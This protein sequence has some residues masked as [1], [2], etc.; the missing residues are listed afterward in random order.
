MSKF[1]LVKQ[2]Y[3]F[4]T[5]S[6][7]DYSTVKRALIDNL[8]LEFPEVF[9]DYTEFDELI[10]II[11]SFAYI[12]ELFAYRL[13]I[14]AQENFIQTAN[15]KQNVIKLADWIGYT[16][17]RGIP[18]RGLF[19][20]ESVV[21]QYDII[22]VRGENLKNREI[23]WND[24]NN[25]FWKSQFLTVLQQS[26]D[27]E[28]LNANENKR[29]Q[30]GNTIVEQ[31]S[32]ASVDTLFGTANI[33]SSEGVQFNI[34]SSSVTSSGFVENTPKSTNKISLF[35][36]DDNTGD[37]SLNTGFFFDVTQGQIS[38]TNIIIDKIIP[39]NSIKVSAANINEFDVWLFDNT[40]NTF[41][42]TV[43]KLFFNN[44][45]SKNIFKIKPVDDNSIELLFGD[46]ILSNIPVGNFTVFYRTSLNQNLLI[47]KQTIT[48]INVS[49][50]LFFNNVRNIISFKISCGTDLSSTASEDMQHIK[51]TASSH[52]EIQDRLVTEYDYNKYLLQDQRV[53]CANTLPVKSI[54]DSSFFTW[55]KQVNS[56]F[57]L[58]FDDMFCFMDQCTNVK[59]YTNQSAQYV[60]DII[61]GVITQ[62]NVIATSTLYNAVN[63]TRTFFRTQT[64][65]EYEQLK[66]KMGIATSLVAVVPTF[67][68]AIKRSTTSDNWIF[69]NRTRDLNNIPIWKY[70]DIIIVDRVPQNTNTIYTVF[71]KET[72]IAIGKNN[73]NIVTDNDL[74]K[75]SFLFNKFN[76]TNNGVP[77]PSSI[78]FKAIMTSNDVDG[79]KVSNC[80]RVQS[81]DIDN[82]NLPDIKT[83]K[84][85][86]NYCLT[87]YQINTYQ[88]GGSYY[89]DVP[90]T[91]EA[92]MP[93][94]Q[95][96]E[97]VRDNSNTI[98]AFSYDVGD[99]IPTRKIKV[100]TTSPYILATIKQ[101]IYVEFVGGLCNVL[102]STRDVFNEVVGYKNNHPTIK[103][104]LGKSDMLIKYT[105]S[106]PF[107]SV[108]DPEQTNLIR[109]NIITK[110]TLDSY[111]AYVL[112][113]KSV[114]YPTSFDLSSSFGYLLTKRMI[115]DNVSLSSGKIVSF[116]GSSSVSQRKAKISI[117]KNPFGFFLSTDI[118]QTV[119][120]TITSLFDTDYVMGEKI[121]TSQLIG[122]ISYKLINEIQDIK[123]I[124]LD[125][126]NYGQEI[127][128]FM[129]GVDE[130]LFPHI[131]HDD[132]V[133]M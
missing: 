6:A 124:S 80:V 120:D 71:V 64:S 12:S 52:Y 131:T 76:L 62:T 128:Y 121:H 16:P 25:V 123:F 110:G 115:S 48:N 95:D 59:T 112:T 26:L 132:I 7:Y 69:E 93:F 35:S 109:I 56:N 122:I 98:V 103:R 102:K 47:P 20:I 61:D 74:T 119:I 41:W 29:V 77:L 97:L 46:G 90:N 107:L 54:G 13:D 3:E 31:Y 44:S 5:F 133:V 78:K 91:N 60:V 49:I 11:N 75:Q 96:I 39:N 108:V 34:L 129:G 21:P 113:G 89:F 53:L 58:L 42:S 30:I 27:E 92:V 14:N 99:F 37:A 32:L 81:Q 85:D 104:V 45:P 43:D 17:K 15:I 1:N 106:V 55:N 72:Y 118:K 87:T 65:D 100:N 28:V 22:D 40:N 57:D 67:P 19:K 38:S 79:V 114:T 18:A 84:D 126:N 116:I 94:T 2:A 63:P 33:S 82:N 4:A 127:D 88:D 70:D 73:F 111:K 51:R 130:L 50:P 117:K 8:R 125:P 68:F 24:T 36:L 83:I 101:Y 23:R 86:V 66:N 105:Y 9:N 10:M